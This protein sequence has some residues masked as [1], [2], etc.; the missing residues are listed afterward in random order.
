MNNNIVKLNNG[1]FKIMQNKLV[2]IDGS[3]I[4]FN[5]MKTDSIMTESKEIGL[6]GYSK[7][8]FIDGQRYESLT[9]IKFYK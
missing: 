9:P 6:I 8:Y 5:T 4:P 3:L 7:V 1:D 2:E